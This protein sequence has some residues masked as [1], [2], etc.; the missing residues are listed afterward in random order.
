MGINNSNPGRGVLTK[1][2]THVT[3][4]SCYHGSVRRVAGDALNAY[5]TCGHA[6]V[7]PL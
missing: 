2:S 5:K 3:K 6:A 1:V 7:G 4:A